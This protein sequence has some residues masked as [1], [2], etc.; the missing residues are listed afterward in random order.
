MGQSDCASENGGI[1]WRSRPGRPFGVA[2]VSSS[3][4]ASIGQRE[5]SR[6]VETKKAPGLGRLGGDL[7]KPKGILL[8]QARAED[9]QNVQ[10]ETAA[11][12]SRGIKQCS[13]LQALS[14]LLSRDAQCKV[15]AK[16]TAKNSDRGAHGETPGNYRHLQASTHKKPFATSRRTNSSCPRIRQS[17]KRFCAIA[18]AGWHLGQTSRNAARGKQIKRG[19]PPWTHP[20]LKNRREPGN[21]C[22]KDLIQRNHVET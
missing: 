17:K 2:S 3:S 18:A 16:S 5:A 19:A 15:R 14:A 21:C 6:G 12:R 20:A 1:A 13:R 7:P 11:V 22:P 10:S 8:A 4:P 9:S